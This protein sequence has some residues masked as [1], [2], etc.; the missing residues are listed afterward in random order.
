MNHI[1]KKFNIDTT[2]ITMVEPKE[3]GVRKKVDIFTDHNHTT[4]YIHT[5]QKSRLLQ[6]DVESFEKIIT[7]LQE[8][9]NIKVTNK[10]IFIDS[11]L[12]SRAKTKF[13]NNNWKV[14][15]I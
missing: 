1:L 10:H 8:H 13:E 14:Y 12:C 6:K 3:I 15:T 7:N 11:P 4:T 2:N 9:F 5:A